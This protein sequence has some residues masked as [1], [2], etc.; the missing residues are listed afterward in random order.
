MACVI[1]TDK[2]ADL[3]YAHYILPQSF[4]P[5]ITEGLYI[6]GSEALGR[7]IAEAEGKEYLYNRVEIN[8]DG[9]TNYNTTV[10]QCA[11]L[12]DMDNMNVETM[13][14]I[15]QLQLNEWITTFIMY[16]TFIALLS[17][18]FIIIRNNIIQAGFLFEGNRIMRLRMLGMDKIQI[19]KMYL[20]QGL[21]ESRWIWLALL[22]TYSVRGFEIYKEYNGSQYQVYI[23]E[24]GT[25]TEDIRKIIRYTMDSR[26]NIWICLVVMLMIV[27]FNVVT[28]YCV[29][30]RFL[31]NMEV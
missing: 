11:E 1:P 13:H 14:E 9:L 16:F 19:K 27:L 7:K 15:K 20:L 8:M 26:V 29:A 30:R 10:K 6:L 4:S 22:V 12:L 17:A 3:K 5:D 2:S 21:Y 23:E 25:Y 31:R 28:R 18:F 24:L